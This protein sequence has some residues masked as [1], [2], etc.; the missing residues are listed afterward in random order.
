MEAR[1]TSPGQNSLCSY[2]CSPSANS[3]SRTSAA[4][5]PSSRRAVG[6]TRGGRPRLR[7]T[8]C[9]RSR[10]VPRRWGRAGRAGRR[11]CSAPRASRSGSRQDQVGLCR[12]AWVGQ[13]SLLGL[14]RLQGKPTTSQ[15]SAPLAKK[16]PPLTELG[17]RAGKQPSDFEAHA[18]AEVG[19]ARWPP[20]RRDVRPP[21]INGVDT[22]RLYR[23]GRDAW[24]E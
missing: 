5:L 21:G 17:W 8:R 20:L 2:R 18:Q 7:R 15:W 14:P 16:Y 3:S 19:G 1:T 11:S 13:R 24:H 6:P 22:G 10:G 9:R 4:V 23:A 12:Q